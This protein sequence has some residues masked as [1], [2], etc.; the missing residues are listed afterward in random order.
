[1]LPITGEKII[2]RFIAQL[3]LLSVCLL[4]SALSENPVKLWSVDLSRNQDFQK[5]MQTPEVLLDPP[6]IDFINDKQ[7]IVSFEDDDPWS[8]DPN[9]K[10]FGFHV[11]EVEANSGMLGRKLSFEVLTASQTMAASDDTFLVLAGEELKRFSNSFQQV[12]GLPTPL[13]LHGRPTEQTAGDRSFLNPRYETWQMDMAPGGRVVVLAHSKGPRDTEFRWLRTEDFT[14]V[15]TTQ[16]ERFRWRMSAGNRA[17]L[18]SRNPDTMLISSSQQTSICARCASAYFI[19]DD[20]IF[21][22][23][24]NKY[25]IRTVSGKTQASGKLNREAFPFHRAANATRFAYAT[26]VY[27]G[28][29]FPLQTHFAAHM[30]VR[31]FDWST[32]RRVTEIGFDEPEKAVSSGFKESAIALSPDG[33]RLLVLNDSMLNCYRLP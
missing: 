4:A 30:A 5:R 29:G 22:D 23:E 26:G 24:G 9:R 2:G 13:K 14:T 16:V 10:P 33:R 15:A 1:M 28:S 12:A 31:V 17:V 8:P 6:I 21:L 18:S 19:N 32:M 7:I 20:L 27:K 3:L 11:L 25:E